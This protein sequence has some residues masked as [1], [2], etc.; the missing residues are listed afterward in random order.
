MGLREITRA[1]LEPHRNRS[2]SKFWVPQNCHLHPL[3][4]E[5]NINGDKTGFRVVLKVQTIYIILYLRT[6][7]LYIPSCGNAGCPYAF[8]SRG[9]RTC[10]TWL[11]SVESALLDRLQLIVNRQ[12]LQAVGSAIP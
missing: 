6:D 12:F 9:R 1:I 5:A 3:K 4:F 8:G 2:I 10:R 7:T 11:T